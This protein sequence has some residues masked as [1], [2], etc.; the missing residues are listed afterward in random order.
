MR[1]IRR[2]GHLSCERSCFGGL[3]RLA[4]GGLA[5][6]PWSMVSWLYLWEGL[7]QGVMWFGRFVG[8]S[9]EDWQVLEP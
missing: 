7:Q 6:A 4:C 1:S 5:F 9:S 3:L 2:R 8:P